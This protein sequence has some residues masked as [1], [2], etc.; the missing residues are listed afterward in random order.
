[1]TSTPYAISTSMGTSKGYVYAPIR[2]PLN[3]SQYPLAMPSHHSGVLTGVRPTPPAFFPGQEPI[4]SDMNMLARAQYTRGMT[5]M[6]VKKAMLYPLSAGMHVREKK[7]E[8]IGKST[9]KV[10]LSV[11]APLSSKSYD[12]NVRRSALRRARSGGS[13]APAKKGSI[14]RRF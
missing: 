12:T 8:A 11:E 13:V 1:M 14:Y 3:S 4:P 9:Y 10:G 2:G 5:S 7:T 6:N